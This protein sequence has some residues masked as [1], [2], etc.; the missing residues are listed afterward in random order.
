MTT[1]I[2]RIATKGAFEISRNMEAGPQG[3]PPI[4]VNESSLLEIRLLAEREPNVVF[5]S[6]AHRI[7]F[8]LLKKSFK[9]VRRS[10]SAGV[11]RITAKEYARD[12]DRNLYNLHERLRRGQYVPTPVR[13]VWIDK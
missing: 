5:T 10:N 4:L 9:K 13:R 3:G 8:P 12:L 2:Q 7:D 1:Q 11:D 6:L